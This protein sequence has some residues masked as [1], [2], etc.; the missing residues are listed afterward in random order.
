MRVVYA[1][2]DFNKVKFIR[3]T[4]AYFVFFLYNFVQP[5]LE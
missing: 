5:D 1:L 3:R 2:D 4:K